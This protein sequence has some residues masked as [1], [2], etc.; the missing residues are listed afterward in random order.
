VFSGQPSV[1]SSVGSRLSL[2]RYS[3]GISA[4]VLP[5][6]STMGLDGLRNQIM[7]SA[8]S[9]WRTIRCA[10]AR[11]RSTIWMYHGIT[12]LKPLLVNCTK[13][14]GLASPFVK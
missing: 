4:S 12:F 2:A 7:R 13:R 11:L 8:P 9:G 10:S 14:A 1:G 3:R 6:P 5:S